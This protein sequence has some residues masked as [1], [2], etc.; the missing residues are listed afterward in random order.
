MS[1]PRYRRR[2]KVGGRRKGGGHD[3]FFCDHTSFLRIVDAD[4]GLW[5]G[6]PLRARDR[7]QI[8]L[9]KYGERFML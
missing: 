7:V 1:W 2:W 8:R 6:R 3:W 9:A 5:K 4:A